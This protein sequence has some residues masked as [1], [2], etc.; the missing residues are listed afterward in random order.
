MNYITV[1]DIYLRFC[2]VFG[3][4]YCFSLFDKLFYF[5]CSPVAIMDAT[6]SSG[7]SKCGPQVITGQQS[8]IHS[9]LK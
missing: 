5:L 1:F 8:Q 7:T 2:S 4:I 6:L 3:E 9:L